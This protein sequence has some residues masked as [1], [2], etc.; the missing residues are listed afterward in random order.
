MGRGWGSW[1]FALLLLALGCGGGSSGTPDAGDVPEDQME[2]GDGV[3]VPEPLRAD[4]FERDRAPPV[5]VPGLPDHAH[6]P[7]AELREQPVAAE[8][9][10]RRLGRRRRGTAV[11]VSGLFSVIAWLCAHQGPPSNGV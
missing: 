5:H 1:A 11:S 4:L 3:V 7:G 6:G 9:R 8:G 2:A 10:P